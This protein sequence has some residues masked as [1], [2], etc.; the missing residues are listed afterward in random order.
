MC[1]GIPMKV[2]ES[3]FFQSICEDKQ[4]NRHTIDTMLTGEQKEGTWLL[5]FLGAAREV[6]D[7]KTADQIIDALSALESAMNG[8]G[9]MDQFFPDLHKREEV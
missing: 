6:L 7:E 1:L 5:T 4:G 9:N 3:G 8:E 2:I